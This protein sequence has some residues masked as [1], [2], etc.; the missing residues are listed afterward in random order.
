MIAEHNE[1][2]NVRELETIK[3]T[4]DVRGYPVCK[5]AETERFASSY[6]ITALLW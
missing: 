4:F 3:Y 1:K 6:S 5:V 2:Q